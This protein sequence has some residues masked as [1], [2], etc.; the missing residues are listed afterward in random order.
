MKQVHAAADQSRHTDHAQPWA[1]G[2]PTTADN[3]L[4]L[5]ENCNYTKQAPRWRVTT[6]TSD[7]HTHTADYTTPTGATYRSTAPPR[8]P[9]I[10]NLSA[11]EIRIGIE[12]ARHA[13]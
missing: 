5:C 6:T 9:T 12:L 1:T 13:A 8:A 11:L 7:H 4:G 2:G 10:I 3:G